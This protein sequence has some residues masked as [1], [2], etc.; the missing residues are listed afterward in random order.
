MV[1]P[2]V[3][4]FTP[5][6]EIHAVLDPRTFGPARNNVERCT[7]GGLDGTAISNM[8]ERIRYPPPPMS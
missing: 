2:M 6:A 4:K 7:A 3:Q 5:C 1:L 8:K